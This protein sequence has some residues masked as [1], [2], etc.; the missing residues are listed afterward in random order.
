MANLTRFSEDFH[1]AETSVRGVAKTNN[2]NSLDAGFLEGLEKTFSE[3]D[4]EYDEKAYENLGET[5]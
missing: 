5:S 2:I 3:W 4:G 1:T